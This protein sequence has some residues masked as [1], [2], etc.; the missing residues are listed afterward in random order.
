MRKLSLIFL[1]LGLALLGYL[2]YDVGPA[3]LWGHLTDIGLGFLWVILVGLTSM[4]FLACAWKDL[5][6]R[7]RATASVLDLFL[8][9][10][11]GFAV[12]E[13]TPG[14][15]A[16]EPVKGA[17]LRGKIP[18][19]DIVSSLILH[20][21]LYIITNFLQI[22][23]GACVGLLWLDLSPVLMWGT[24][25]VTVVVAMILGLLAMAIRWGMAERFMKAIR[26]IRLPIRNIEGIIEGARKADEQAKTFH[27]ERP[28]AFWRAFCWIFLA[29]AMAVVEIWVI[30]VLIAHPTD[31]ATLML[32][33][34]S[35]LLVYVIFFFVPSQMGA[36]E[37]GSTVIFELLRF[38]PATGLLMELVRRARKLSVVLI[39][40]VIFGVRSIGNGRGAGRKGAGTDP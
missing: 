6:Y 30:L 17:M 16:G 32:L 19:P 35:S 38:N 18:G 21:Y 2:I 9:G 13:L 3:K 24:I 8:A 11:V 10:L 36:N 27:R 29:R 1:A 5:L 25:V 12:N 28:A 22:A 31:F 7:E 34:A 14:S 39:G 37:L 15:V 4:F 20:N 33:Q 23:I 40:L 26:F